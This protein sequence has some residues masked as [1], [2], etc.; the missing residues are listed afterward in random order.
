MSVRAVCLG[1]LVPLAPSRVAPVGQMTEVVL[2][3]ER[4]WPGIP[5]ENY[6]FVRHLACY[7]WAATVIGEQSTPAELPGGILDAGS[8]EGYGSAELMGSCH[9]SVIAVEL[10]APT[11][12]HAR[13][14]YPDMAHVRANLVALPFADLSFAAAVSLQV[15]EHIWDP[16]SYLRELARCTRGPIVIS[17]PNRPVHSPGLARGERPAN[18]FHVCEF[19]APELADLLND[20]APNR[21]PTIYGLVHGERLRAW[22]HS[23][24]SLPSALL[25]S[26]VATDA[27]EFAQ[28][29]GM[30][31]FTVEPFDNCEA[32]A[33]IHDLVALW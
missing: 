11:A 9:R 10:D 7:R 26:T 31:D 8:G 33:E 29:V 24:G 13:S 16:L 28:S 12:A 14:R 15:V 19:D 25:A 27:L 2:T 21:T 30:D 23:K 1:N 32:T 17:T 18:P 20:A 5:S 4:T 22:E 3:G 6:W